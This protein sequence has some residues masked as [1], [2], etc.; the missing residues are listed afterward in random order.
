[1]LLENSVKCME[2]TLP[3]HLPKLQQRSTL[4]CE[5]AG[6]A[7]TYVALK[8]IARIWVDANVLATAELASD[9]DSVESADGDDS[10][11]RV[12]AERL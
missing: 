10:R 11:W 8:S 7:S 6:A 12:T 4:L 3:N 9:D 1:M 2:L 5:S